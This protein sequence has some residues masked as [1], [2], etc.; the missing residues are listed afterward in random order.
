[1]N[2]IGYKTVN[3]VWLNETVSHTAMSDEFDNGG[4]TL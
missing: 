1:M 2:F 4:K 3:P